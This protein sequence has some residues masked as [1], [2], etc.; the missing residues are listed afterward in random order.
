MY[1]FWELCMKEWWDGVML[2]VVE[3]GGYGGEGKVRAS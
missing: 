3:E 2:V 1:G